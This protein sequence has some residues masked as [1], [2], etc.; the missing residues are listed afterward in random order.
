[1]AGFQ[2]LVEVRVD[3]R[4]LDRLKLA[5]LELGADGFA[6]GEAR[7]INHVGNKAF[8]RVRRETARQTGLKV[9]DVN[10]AMRKRLATAG[11]PVYRII[12]R[13]AHFPAYKFGGRQTRKGAS[14]APWNKRR[15]FPGT[16]VA[17]MPTGHVGIFHRKTAERRPIKELWGPAVPV[18]MIKGEAKSA[19]EQLVG[20]E[21]MPRLAHELDREV[22]RVKAK[23][24]L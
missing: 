5:F 16:F 3:T 14:A 2:P 24:G 9:G 23:Y 20:A 21:L 17:R 19:F 12:G 15:V 8:T 18:E 22:L 7:A 1:M 6:R 13:G 10:A 11:E 4:E